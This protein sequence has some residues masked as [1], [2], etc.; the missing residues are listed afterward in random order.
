MPY[1]DRFE[2]DMKHIAFIEIAAEDNEYTGA[3]PTASEPHYGAGY[4][5]DRWHLNGHRIVFSNADTA[6]T[7]QTT[8]SYNEHV[9]GMDTNVYPTKLEAYPKLECFDPYP[10]PLLVAGH[11]DLPGGILTAGPL[12]RK[13]TQYTFKNGSPSTSWYQREPQFVTLQVPLQD[14]VA[15]IDIYSA[16]GRWTTIWVKRGAS[17]R[18]GNMRVID[19]FEDPYATEAPREHFLLFYKLSAVD[20]G[21]DPPLPALTGVPVNSCSVQGWP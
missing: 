17:V 5:F 13:K 1:D 8:W 14:E 3:P 15:Q 6:A 7:L 18:I 11:V 19:I 2:T 10:P 21:D 4:L 12:E 9:A 16:A 20:V